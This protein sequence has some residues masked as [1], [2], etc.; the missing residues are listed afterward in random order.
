[1]TLKEKSLYHQIHPLKL[2]T[3]IGCESLSLYFFRRHD[4]VPGLVT[5]FAPPIA[6]SLALILCADF[7][8]I[9][10]S[11]AGAH[12]RRYVTTSHWPHQTVADCHCDS[13]PFACMD[14]WN[15]KSV[16]KTAVWTYEVWCEKA[17]TVR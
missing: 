4:L 5:H 7:E 17:A 12:L 9:K 1:M 16:S 2:A 10:E 8:S 3:D 13:K 14:N 11:R 6:V 15:P